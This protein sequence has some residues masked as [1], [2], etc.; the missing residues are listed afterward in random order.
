MGSNQEMQR[1]LP[2]VLL[3]HSLMPRA[4]AKLEKASGITLLRVPAPEDRTGV[5]AAIRQH[6]PDGILCMLVDKIDAELLD[7]AGDSLKIVSTVSVGY[8]HISTQELKRRNI[9]LGHTPDVL[10]DAVAETT[11]LL[12]LMATRRVKESTHALT[13]GAWSKWSMNFLLGM[14]LTGKTIGFIGMGRVA[15]KTAKTFLDSFGVKQIL[16]NGP[17]PKDVAGEF[18]ENLSEMLPLCDVVIVLCALNKQ[19]QHLMNYNMFCKMKPTA[20]FVNAAR[21]GIVNQVDL[22]RALK[23]CSQR[24]MSNAK[25]RK[26]CRRRVGRPGNGTYRSKRSTRQ[27]TQSHSTPPHW[28]FNA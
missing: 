23:V 15:R 3:T 20:Y 11:I 4:Q 24:L 16:Y 19:T 13:S 7:A 28:I 21:G 22:A 10:T 5:L 6:K 8:D 25:G 26:A 14:G 27:C 18:H 2:K 1:M 12:T 9:K 17:S